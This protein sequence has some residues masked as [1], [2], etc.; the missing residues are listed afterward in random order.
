MQ[1]RTFQLGIGGAEGKYFWRR[2]KDARKFARKVHSAAIMR[3]AY[4]RARA[5][6]FDKLVRVDG[7]GPA[8][9]ASAKQMNSELREVVQL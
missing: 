7:L 4:V 5:T 6:L 9:F 3:A 2:L 8:V 1:T